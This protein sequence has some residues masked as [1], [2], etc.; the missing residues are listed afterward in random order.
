MFL[1]TTLRS[2]SVSG[3]KVDSCTAAIRGVYAAGST[4]TSISLGAFKIKTSAWRSRS[5]CGYI[6]MAS[7]SRSQ[8]DEGCSMKQP[9]P[10]SA[11]PPSYFRLADWI[12]IAGLIF[13]EFYYL[14]A[15]QLPT[16]ITNHAR[17][18]DYANF[19]GVPWRI[20]AQ[21]HYPPTSM[22]FPY[23]PSAIAMMLP[24]GLLPQTMGFRNLDPAPSGLSLDFSVERVAAQWRGEL[25]GK[26][27]FRLYRRAVHRVSPQLGLSQP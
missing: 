25:A 5:A 23:P 1:A 11:W 27:G 2:N 9:K 17:E 18:V 6:D 7:S 4:R 3:R 16:L 24:I 21:G 22:P 20:L 13:V 15:F 19:Y 26:M 10:V 14:T 12:G 8:L